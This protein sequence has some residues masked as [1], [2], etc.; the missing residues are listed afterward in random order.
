MLV[1]GI[2]GSVN[3]LFDQMYSWFVVTSSETR[4]ELYT[5]TLYATPLLWQV[6]LRTSLYAVVCKGSRVRPVPSLLIWS[7]VTHLL[8]LPLSARIR[9][10]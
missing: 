10:D 9:V 3:G 6:P 5:D 7:P 4:G 8:E 2:V 1:V